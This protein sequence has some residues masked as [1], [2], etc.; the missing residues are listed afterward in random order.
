MPCRLLELLCRWQR[1]SSA[2]PSA[3]VSLLNGREPRETKKSS[4]A[5]H[6]ATV[7]AGD[8]MK[9]W[10]SKPEYSTLY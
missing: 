6:R 7:A 8:A 1:V 3:K 5:A 9:V 2:P 10:C 4:A